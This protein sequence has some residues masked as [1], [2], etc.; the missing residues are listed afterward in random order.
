MG[1]AQIKEQLKSEVDPWELLEDGKIKPSVLIVFAEELQE[2]W[3][4]ALWS[5]HKNYLW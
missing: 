3:L 5:N 2:F 1:Q 4:H